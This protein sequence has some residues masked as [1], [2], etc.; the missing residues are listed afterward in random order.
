MRS[1]RRSDYV[2]SNPVSALEASMPPPIM[3]AR[4]FI[5]EAVEALRGATP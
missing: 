4:I 2:T 3:L 5:G 1:F